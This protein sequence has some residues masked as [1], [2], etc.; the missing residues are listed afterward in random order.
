MNYLPDLPYVIL[1]VHTESLNRHP[2][3][4]VDAFPHI[5]ETAGGDGVLS[6]LDQVFGYDV[7]SGE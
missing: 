3:V 6:R 5:A 4:V 1:L 2:F 7:G